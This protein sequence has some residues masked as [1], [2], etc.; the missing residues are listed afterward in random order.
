LP[1][2]RLRN[3]FI[4]AFALAVASFGD[5]RCSSS[6]ILDARGRRIRILYASKD[7]R[8][9]EPGLDWIGSVE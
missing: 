4:K 9:R 7:N 3:A 8:F 6:S 1:S 5:T 2:D